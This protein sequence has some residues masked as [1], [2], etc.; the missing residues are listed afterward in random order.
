M[1][2]QHIS[3]ETI[4]LNSRRLLDDAVI[5]RDAQSYRTA[6]SLAILSME[7]TGKACLVKWKFDGHIKR[8]ITKDIRSGHVSKQRIFGVYHWAKAI[9]EVVSSQKNPRLRQSRLE[10]MARKK[11]QIASIPII[12]RAETGLYDGIKQLGFYIDI[13]DDL[14][15]MQ[16]FDIFNKANAD[17]HISEARTAMTIIDAAD[18]MHS[19]M[20]DLYEGGEIH[21]FHKKRPAIFRELIQHESRKQKKDDLN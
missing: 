8:D 12:H 16:P 1:T 4:M 11:A 15:V 21:T 2:S 14:S 13:D 10:K 17:F 19:V 18:I 20:A 5:L 6:I 7:E 3:V 9:R